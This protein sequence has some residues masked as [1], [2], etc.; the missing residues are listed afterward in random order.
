[1]KGGILGTLAKKYEQ[2]LEV[3]DGLKQ[4]LLSPSKMIARTTIHQRAIEFALFL[5]AD[6]P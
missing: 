1:M 5:F 6:K 3:N 2:D 4:Y